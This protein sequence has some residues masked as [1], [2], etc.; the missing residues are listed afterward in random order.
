MA[1]G[2]KTELVRQ[3]F[4]YL[5]GEGYESRLTKF[6]EDEVF[7]QTIKH[8]DKDG[9]HYLN[10]EVQTVQV[11]NGQSEAQ[12]TVSCAMCQ[13]CG[14]LYGKVEDIHYVLEYQP[15]Q[16]GQALIHGLN[17]NATEM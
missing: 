14:A 12:V 16:S 17:L 6:P 9:L 2:S 5:F 13:L 4:L 10:S 15:T 11:S 7:P 3:A 1:L 8:F